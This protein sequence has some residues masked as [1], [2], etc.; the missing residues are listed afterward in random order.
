MTVSESD[1][2]RCVLGSGWGS[3][4]PEYRSL[5]FYVFGHNYI[6]SAGELSR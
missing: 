6:G 4:I 2:E 1:L 3:Q 5:A